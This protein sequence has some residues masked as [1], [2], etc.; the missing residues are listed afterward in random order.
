MMIARRRARATRAL[1]MVDFRESVA[2]EPDR[3]QTGLARCLSIE[4]RV[5][6]NND[7]RLG[8][9]F[10]FAH[11]GLKNIGMGFGLLGVVG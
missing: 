11:G 5:T 9:A 8:N 4:G 6:D 3:A 2:T 7:L 1:R 10:Q